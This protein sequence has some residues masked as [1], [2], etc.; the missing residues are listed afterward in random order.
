MMEFYD[1]VLV[2]DYQPRERRMAAEYAERN[3][4]SQGIPYTL[5]QPLGPIPSEVVKTYGPERAR[6]IFRPWR[7]EVDI[8]A[9]A[10]D[11]LIIS[12]VKIF[13]ILDGFSKLLQY[14]ALVPQTP[15]LEPYRNRS[16]E[17]R[18]VV[19]WVPEWLPER[20]AQENVKIDVYRPDWID[21]YVEEMHKYW[22][23]EYRTLREARRRG[24]V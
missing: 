15:E 16:V 11:R 13:K 4:G 5:G 17:A 8:A 19:P 14:R 9:F 6:A 20:A 3:F 21:Q 12:E 10:Q 2:G 22:T 23:K 18:I 24:L 7:P 1:K